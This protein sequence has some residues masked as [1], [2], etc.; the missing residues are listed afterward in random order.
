VS[1]EEVWLLWRAEAVVGYA[2]THVTG[3]VLTIRAVLVLDG[4]DPGDAVA[5]LLPYTAAEYVQVQVDGP[6]E[7]TS[8]MRIGFP[9]AQTDWGTFMIKPLTPELTLDDARRMLAVDTE[10]FLFSMLDVT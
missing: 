1:V 8:L 2:L 5:A 4:H 9:P 6:G 3:A 10:R 7:A